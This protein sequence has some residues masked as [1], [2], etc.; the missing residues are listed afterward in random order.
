MQKSFFLAFHYNYVFDFI[1]FLE[2]VGFGMAPP[3]SDTLANEISP[4]KDRTVFCAVSR[5][6]LGGGQFGSAALLWFSSPNLDVLNWRLLLIYGAIPSFFFLFFAYFFLIESPHW[7]A[8]K[9]RQLEAKSVIVHIAQLNGSDL[10]SEDI[11]FGEGSEDSSMTAVP[12]STQ[13]K[14]LFSSQFLYTTVAMCFHIFTMNYLYYGT[15]YSLPQVLPKVQSPISPAANLMLVSV[16]EMIGVI[17]LALVFERYNRKGS[18][19]SL[20]FIMGFATMTFVSCSHPFLL[21][22]VVHG[23]HGLEAVAVGAIFVQKMAAIMSWVVLTVYCCEVFP[24]VCLRN[25]F[26]IFLKKCDFVGF[27]PMQ[28][29]R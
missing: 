20:M 23:G 21:G 26:K 9:G 29:F 7:L 4:S 6:L 8:S 13:A 22:D 14:H 5:V 25:G 3:A 2:G 24:T 1:R 19:Q 16:G 11:I 27:Q 12:W 18:M 17:C 15:I 28:Y 10:T